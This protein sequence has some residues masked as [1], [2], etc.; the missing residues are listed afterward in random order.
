MSPDGKPVQI[1]SSAL[2]AS[3]AQNAVGM[4]YLTFTNIKKKHCQELSLISKGLSLQAHKRYL[5]HKV[6]LLLRP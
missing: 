3:A 5:T 2:Q 4:W 1:N 6:F